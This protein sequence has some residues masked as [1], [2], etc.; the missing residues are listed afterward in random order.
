MMFACDAATQLR[1]LFSLE[2]SAI[3]P[4]SNEPEDNMSEEH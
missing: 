3:S 2:Q 1:N 4:G